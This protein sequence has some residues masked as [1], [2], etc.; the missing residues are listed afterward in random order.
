MHGRREAVVDCGDEKRWERTN[1]LLGYMVGSRERAAAV[2]ERLWSVLQFS[3][4]CC[5]RVPCA[6]VMYSNI[7]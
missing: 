1:L 3:L 7:S 2:S 6:K 4:E 5:A